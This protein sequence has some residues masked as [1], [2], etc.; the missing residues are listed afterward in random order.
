MLGKVGVSS[1]VAR[2]TDEGLSL[3]G[4]ALFEGCSFVAMSLRQLGVS[5]DAGFAKVCFRR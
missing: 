5:A 1:D 2:R 3:R 4:F